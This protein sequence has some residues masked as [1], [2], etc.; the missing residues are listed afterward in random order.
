E[1]RSPRPGSRIYGRLGFKRQ[2]SK[3]RSEYIGQDPTKPVSKG[4]N[5]S[6]PHQP[7]VPVAA[8][9]TRAMPTTTR[10]TLSIPPTLDFTCMLL[11][12]QKIFPGSP[13]D[14]ATAAVGL[15]TPRRR[16]DSDKWSGAKDRLEGCH[17]L[18]DIGVIDAVVQG[19]GFAAECHQ[20]LVAH[21]RQVLRQR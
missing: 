21:L 3:P 19:L 20:S 11:L 2:V 9:A 13:P 1:G 16:S 10:R 8:K 17:Q 7:T 18:F 15:P 14:Q 4:T 6:Q 12:Q 5:P